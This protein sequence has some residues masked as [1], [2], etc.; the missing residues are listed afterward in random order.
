[1]A[2][3]LLLAICVA[4]LVQALAAEPAQQQPEGRAKATAS[5]HTV[6]PVECTDGYF[7]WQ[8]LGLAYRCVR[9]VMEL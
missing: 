1:M 2:Q 9:Q 5:I 3:I 8:V 4:T 7:E 6:V